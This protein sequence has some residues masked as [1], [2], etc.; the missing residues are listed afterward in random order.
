MIDHRLKLLS[1]SS[2]CSL[3]SCPR[4]YQ[5]TK[6]SPNAIKEETVDTAFG[7]TF[8]EGIQN[9][10]LGLD[11][12]DVIIKSIMLWSL[13]LEDEKQEKSIWS[14]INALN[15]FNLIKHESALAEYEVAMFEGKPATELGFT[16]TFPEGFFFRGFIDVVLKHKLTGSLLVVDVKTTGSKYTHPAKFANSAQAIGYSIVLDKIEPNLS[17]YDVMYYEYSTSTKKFTD[18]VFSIDPLR[19]A[20]W[21]R[22]IM[23]DINIIQMYA[24][25][26]PEFPLHGESCVAFNRACQ[27]IDVCTMSTK[28]I[29][30]NSYPQ[31]KPN[32]EEEEGVE[33]KYQFKFT[34]DELVNT[35]LERG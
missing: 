32:N 33:D 7:K 18:M 35:Q 28:A 9:I 3:H 8:G 13:D 2:C 12:Q 16:I 21:L 1:H 22:D 24:A 26:S 14:A 10:L 11:F 19:K 15:K 30:G 4:K 25:N 27:F 23:Y 20:L 5:L 17:Q 34:L 29:C 31:V 6:I